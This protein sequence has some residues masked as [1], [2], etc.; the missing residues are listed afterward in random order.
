MISFCGG[1]Y[2]E[3]EVFQLIKVFVPIFCLTAFFIQNFCSF[4]CSCLVRLPVL[5][6]TVSAPINVVDDLGLSKMNMVSMQ[7]WSVKYRL[8]FLNDRDRIEFWLRFAT[9]NLLLMTNMIE[10]Q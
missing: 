1:I 8:T 2:E 10:L 4:F 3:Y 5:Q 9:K 7:D 6:P